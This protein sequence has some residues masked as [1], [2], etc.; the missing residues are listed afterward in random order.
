MARVYTTVSIDEA[1]SYAKKILFKNK[2]T[3]YSA[4]D[5]AN[6][7]FENG[8]FVYPKMN[9]YVLTEKRRNKVCLPEINL[10][11]KCN[12]CKAGMEFYNRTDYRNNFTYFIQ[13]C[14]ECHKLKYKSRLNATNP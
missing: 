9:N 10:C 5:V 4:S 2:L 6:E 1:T 11:T 3:Y 12:I 13:P 7:G 14:K 8:V